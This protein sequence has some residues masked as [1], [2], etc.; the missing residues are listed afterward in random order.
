MKNAK[1][2]SLTIAMVIFCLLYLVNSSH[3]IE[4]DYIGPSSGSLNYGFTGDTLYGQAHFDEVYSKVY[5]YVDKVGDGKPWTLI[6]TDYGNG[7]DPV[8]YFS[9]TFDTGSKS[10]EEYEITA[11]VYAV[12]GVDINQ[13]SY[14]V[15]IW[16]P[17]EEVITV[18]DELEI[19]DDIKIGDTYAFR[20]QLRSS[21]SRYTFTDGKIEVDGVETAVQI[22]EEAAKLAFKLHRYYSR[23]CGSFWRGADCNIKS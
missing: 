21:D 9:H 22:L 14:T 10:G 19:T 17:A 11:Y 3:A 20:G 18:P 7:T 2:Q 6:S 15:G 23:E 8:S 5:W 13:D 4:V 16:T 1:L 12:N